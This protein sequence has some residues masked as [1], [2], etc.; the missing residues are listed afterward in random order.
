[1][2]RRLIG[3]GSASCGDASSCWNASG[4][5]A[6]RR[7]ATCRFA[8]CALVGYNPTPA[9]RR[10]STG[11]PTPRCSPTT[12]SLRPSIRPPPAQPLLGPAGDPH[13]YR[14]IHPGAPHRAGGGVRGHPRG[15]P[16]GPPAGPRGGRL[17]PGVRRPAPDG[18]RHPRRDGV[19][20]A[21]PADRQQGRPP[22]A[23]GAEEAVDRLETTAKCRALRVS[24]KTGTGLRELRT[25]LD[26]LAARAVRETRTNVPVP[27]PAETPG[28]DERAGS[29]AEAVPALALALAGHIVF[30]GPAQTTCPVGPRSISPSGRGRWPAR[31]RAGRHAPRSPGA[32]PRASCAGDGDLD[33]DP[34][35][36]QVEAERDEGQPAHPDPAVQILDLAAVQEETAAALGLVVL[37]V[38]HLVLADVDLDQPGLTVLDPNVALAEVGETGAER[39]DL[40]AGQLD[41]GLEELQ[42]VVLMAGLAVAG[43]DR[44]FPVEGWGTWLRL[45]ADASTGSRSKWGPRGMHGAAGSRHRPQRR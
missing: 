6:G 42:E 29:P 18:A 32:C 5:P 26:A 21:H 38:A 16:P 43:E 13:R 17:P 39:L 20:S 19:R 31:R 7:A 44:I 35:V 23:G 9:S 36:L 24:A 27:E 11:S 8:A 2:D 14:R 41:A 4:A 45:Y 30:G 15:G 34:V 3:S 28:D 40:G 37:P 33:L 25:A 12:S 22:G 1:V 10:C